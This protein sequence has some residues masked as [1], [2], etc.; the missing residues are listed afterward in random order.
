MA[1][2][3]ATPS[4]LSQEIARGILDGFDA[5]YRVFRAA[6]ASA[7][8]RF[9]RAEWVEL[10]ASTRERIQ[11]YD[12]RVREAVATLTQRFPACTDEA[13]WPSIKQAYI[14]LLYEHLQPELAETFFNSVACRLLD[15]RYYRNDHIFWR[16]AV[17]TE[18]LVG[19]QP[20]YR[21]AYDRGEGMRGALR[22]LLLGYGLKNP[23]QDLERDLRCAERAVRR[24]FPAGFTVQPD[25]HLQALSS[26]FF[27][28]KAAYLV[29]RARNG[30]R[31]FPFVVPVLQDERGALFLDALLLAPLHVRSVFSLARAYFM[32]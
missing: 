16:P 15:R 5:H 2:A 19:E 17:S 1:H 11:S 14:V 6:S 12:L 28:N 18:H 3:A 27:R 7:R 24:H 30:G 10:A 4:A 13:L 23:W 26:L 31:D 29:G 25:F 22:E 21:S 8:E 20:A 9:E 32:V